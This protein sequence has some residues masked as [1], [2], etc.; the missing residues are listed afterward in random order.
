[1]PE[2][3]VVCLSFCIFLN[4][5][6]QL[7]RLPLNNGFVVVAE[8]DQIMTRLLLSM[9][10]EAQ[11]EEMYVSLTFKSS[12]FFVSYPLVGQLTVERLRVVW[13]KSSEFVTSSVDS[14]VSS[15]AVI[16]LITSYAV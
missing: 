9:P 8:K 15:L 1:M 13:L 14:C 5:L 6:Q 3:V 16:D 11:T 12:K 2:L 10:N 4:L 7:L